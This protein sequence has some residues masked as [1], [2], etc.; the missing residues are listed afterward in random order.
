LIST[1][2][3]SQGSEL[4]RLDFEPACFQKRA[5]HL[6]SPGAGNDRK[7]FD[8]MKLLDGFHFRFVLDANMPHKEVAQP[9]S[10]EGADF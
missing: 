1:H 9:F 5:R 3:F 2:D 4:Q 7:S 10:A 8:E 6:R